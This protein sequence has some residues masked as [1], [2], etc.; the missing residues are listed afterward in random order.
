MILQA[1]YSLTQRCR[2]SQSWAGGNI[3][4]A[5]VMMMMMMMMLAMMMVMMM[6]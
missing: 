4:M 3:R 1:F 5:V 2:R 6:L